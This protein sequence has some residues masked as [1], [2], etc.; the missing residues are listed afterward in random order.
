MIF[1]SH[2]KQVPGQKLKWT[3]S[4]LLNAG[5]TVWKLLLLGSGRILYMPT[6]SC[7]V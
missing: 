7:D 6:V 5:S 3:V 4:A 2:P 1:L